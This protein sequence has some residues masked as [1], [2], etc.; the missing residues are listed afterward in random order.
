[1]ADLPIVCTLSPGE[2]SAKREQ[3][4]P[5]LVGRAESVE[6]T[7]NGYRLRFA[8]SSDVLRAIT[9]VIDAERR[10]CRFLRF[11]LSVAE[12]LGP[13]TLTLTGPEG[14]ADALESLFS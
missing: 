4:L 11:D 6:R 9:D 1:M 2:L 5:G 10:C 13:L 7:Q 3:L 14:T 12:G 8:A